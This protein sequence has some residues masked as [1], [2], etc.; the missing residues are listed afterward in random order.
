MNKVG[1]V[2]SDI[3]GDIDRFISLTD[4]HQLLA[5]VPD[6]LDNDNLLVDEQ[7]MNLLDDLAADPSLQYIAA[8]ANVNGTNTNK[9]GGK[10]NKSVSSS[11]RVSAGTGGKKASA[12]ASVVTTAATIGNKG[13]KAANKAS[14]APIPAPLP[15]TN[16]NTSSSSTDVPVGHNGLPLTRQ[17]FYKMRPK[18]PRISKHDP[19]RAYASAFAAAYNSCDFDHIWEFV[20]TYCTKDILFVT[21]W[22]GSELYVNFPKY[23]EVR[24]IESVSE[25]WFSRCIIV[26]DYI[27]ELKETKL[28]VRSDG[29]STVLTSF[30]ILATRL[31]DGEISDSIICRPASDQNFATTAPAVVELGE[32]V[33]NES[34]NIAPAAIAVVDS[35]HHAP[36]VIKNPNGNGQ[37]GSGIESGYESEEAERVEKICNRVFDKLKKILVQHTAIEKRKATTGSTTTDPTNS[38]TEGEKDDSDCK[39]RK[40]EDST[41]GRIDLFAHEGMAGEVGSSTVM[42]SAA[43]PRKRLPSNK[44]ITL[45]GTA[46]LHLNVDHKIHQ[47]DLTF[48]L[49]E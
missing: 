48:S 32:I 7:D 37:D 46:T 11:K 12:T 20:T 24:G 42:N 30:T 4:A 39:R 14:S 47:M 2:Y 27:L 19:R 35:E 25:Y 38:N 43:T 18:A 44:S 33:D 49:Q 45:L 34:D 6:I 10:N 1:S 13:L 41:D 16:P 17:Q 31:Y 23:L 26:P 8:H 5:G 28:Y 40:V 36:P 3:H 9:K 29:I 15:S 21:R 22:V